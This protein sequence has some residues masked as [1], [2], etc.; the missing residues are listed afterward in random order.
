M[1]HPVYVEQYSSPA[2]DGSA[3]SEL[4]LC[5]AVAAGASDRPSYGRVWSQWVRRL[6]MRTSVG[7]GGLHLQRGERK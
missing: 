7:E 1:N 4:T 5:A 6:L 3:D 2:V